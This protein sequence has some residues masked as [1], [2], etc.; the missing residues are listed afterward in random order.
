MT[1]KGESPW[2]LIDFR[3][4]T[5]ATDTALAKTAATLV[6]SGLPTSDALLLCRE[7]KNTIRFHFLSNAISWDKQ[8][9]KTG[10]F[11]LVIMV[12]FSVVCELTSGFFL[13]VLRKTQAR[14]NSELKQNP[15][16]LK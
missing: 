14:N 12:T 2:C 5:I 13:D 1:P 7:E 3:C 15:Q 10:K 11:N 6:G 4:G 16:K 9:V 8:L